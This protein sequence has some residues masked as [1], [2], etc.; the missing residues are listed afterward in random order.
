MD[1]MKFLRFSACLPFMAQINFA[2]MT[3]IGTLLFF[4]PI[5]TLVGC[6]SAT[7]TDSATAEG[8]FKQ[9]Q[10]FEK[11]ERYEEAIAKYSEVK[12]KYPYS[13]LAVDAELKIA[14]LNFT[15][16]AFIEAQSSYQL[17][18]EFH[19]KHPKADYVT[20]RLGLSYFNQLPS[21]IDRDL[22]LADKAILYF[23][24]TINSFPNSEYVK[25]AKQ[26]RGDALKMLAEKELYVASFYAKRDQY[27]SALKRYEMVLKTYPDLGFGPKALYGAAK[28]AFESGEKDRG[29]QHLKNLY[30]LYPSSDDAK[31][32]R[33][34]FKKYGAN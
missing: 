8:A 19:P 23:D 15:R 29:L 32:A 33:D 11:D 6:S 27:D 5:A 31:R 1:V 14:D 25:E 13:K 22:S 18:K 3:M 2:M 30:S 10:E 12:N 21:T 7:V 17:F 4:S 26:K 9:G 16:E 20:F 28:S 34:D 24:E